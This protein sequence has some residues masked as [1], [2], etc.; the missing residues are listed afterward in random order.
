MIPGS[1]GFYAFAIPI[2]VLAGIG[3]SQSLHIPL[4]KWVTRKIQ[5]I[6]RP[7]PPYQA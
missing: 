5:D 1:R 2:S 6:R 4:G 7:P 3:F